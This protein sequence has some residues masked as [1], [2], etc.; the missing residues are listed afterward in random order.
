MIVLALA[1]GRFAALRRVPVWILPYGTAS[2][3]R[4]RV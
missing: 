2:T 1:A 4:Q 3:T